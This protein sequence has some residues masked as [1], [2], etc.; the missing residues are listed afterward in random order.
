MKRTRQQR[1]VVVGGGLGGLSAAACLAADG[2]Q[3]DL[4][5]KNQHLGG[6]LNVLEKDG[7]SFDL[8]PSI[9][10][11]PHL[12]RRIWERAGKRM[13]PD[14][15]FQPVEP[16]WRSFFED[17]THLDLLG[18]SGA[19]DAELKRLGIGARG[20]HRFLDYS[21]RLYE[22]SEKHYLENGSDTL[23]DV[24]AGCSPAELLRGTDLVRSV[25]GGVAAY[26][27]DPHLCTML[28]FFVK[29]VGSSAY[30]APATLNLMPWSQMV[31]GLWYV[32]GGMYNLARGL[33]KLLK[34]LGVKVHMGAEVTKLVTQGRTVVA[35]QLADGSEIPADIVVSNMEVIPAYRRLLGEQGLRVKAYEKIFEP[36]CSGLVLHL[37]LD[38]L[39]P[40]LRHHNFFFSKDQF[41]HFEAVH[42]KHLL[43]EDPTLYVVHPSTSDPSVAPEGHHVLKVLPHIPYVQDRPFTSAEY[44]ALEERVLAKLERM[45]LTDLRR[46]VVV[47]DMLVPE[48]L[49][50]MYYSNRG[51]IYGVVSNRQNMG[52]KANKTSALY[53]NLYFVGGSVNPGG[54]TCMVVLSGQHVARRI[55]DRGMA[56]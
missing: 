31:G 27:D 47:E 25:A 43:P 19:M 48:D 54:G 14:V 5:E 12:F 52:L 39:Y 36:A 2:F 18:D 34:E 50:R 9:I 4:C 46:H 33:A 45:G 37:G 40:E 21:R 20:Y 15:E 1:I 30:D 32:K 23:G 7:F 51:A 26:V 49:E 13:E 11:L 44:L 55:R 41:R 42:R 28:G 29:Y 38:K 17:G 10:I 16:Q 6:K 35:A 3:V 56:L 8:G 24:L 53:D 22:F